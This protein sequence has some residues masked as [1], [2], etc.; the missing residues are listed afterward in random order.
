MLGV[1]A[2][3]SVHTHTHGEGALTTNLSGVLMATSAPAAT[4]A[5]TLLTHLSADEG[6]L[7]D[8]PQQV[9]G[10]LVMQGHLRGS[11]VLHGALNTFFLPP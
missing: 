7:C 9:R 8:L 3:A 10:H 6:H 2:C 5:K 4:M 1:C 11:P